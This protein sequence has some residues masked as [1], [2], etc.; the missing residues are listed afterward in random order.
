[1]PTSSQSSASLGLAGVWY[2]F[3]ISY[4]IVKDAQMR[5]VYPAPNDVVAMKACQPVPAILCQL[6]A[7][8]ES[9]TLRCTSCS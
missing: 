1:M 9:T 8:C 4:S 2:Q 5:V 6:L 7:S 3:W